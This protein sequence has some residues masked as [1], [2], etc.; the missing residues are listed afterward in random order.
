MWSC[1]LT[2]QSQE[3]KWKLNKEYG[4][5]GTSNKSLK[6]LQDWLNTNKDITK[7]LFE[8][9]TKWKSSYSL[10]C[11]FICSW[12]SF[13]S[14]LIVNSCNLTFYWSILFI[15]QIR[16]TCLSNR[17]L[18]LLMLI[19]IHILFFDFHSIWYAMLNVLWIRIELRRSSKRGVCP[20]ERDRYM[21][22]TRIIRI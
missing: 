4:S 18:K 9:F 11:L 21:R 2:F 1:D 14:I 3:M 20:R 13:C 16:S 6:C 7:F 8:R 19:S 12:R 17:L 15:S 5:P 22:L 10:S